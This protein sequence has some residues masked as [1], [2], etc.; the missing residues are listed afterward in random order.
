MA[1]ENLATLAAGA[2]L[3][4]AASS[5]MK[6]ELPSMTPTST[7]APTPTPAPRAP[8]TPSATAALQRA[9]AGTSGAG[10]NAD[11]V[12]TSARQREA[13]PAAVMRKTLLGR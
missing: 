2:G 9:R 4:A 8:L 3:A 10:G 6:S 5:A 13:E 12:L 11:I 7:P 1:L